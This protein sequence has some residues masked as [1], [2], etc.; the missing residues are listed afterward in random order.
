MKKLDKVI[1]GG[2]HSFPVILTEEPE[3]GY[4]VVNPAFDGCYSQGETVEDALANIRE[5]TEMCVEEAL[6]EGKKPLEKNIS[7]HLIHA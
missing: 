7:L 6:A 1:S 3:G 4:V 2:A 5:V